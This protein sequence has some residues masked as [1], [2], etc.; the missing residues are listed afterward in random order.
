[1]LSI[2][3]NG[4]FIDRYLD[5]YQCQINSEYD[6]E[7]SFEAIDGT[8]VRTFLGTR[9]VLNV[10]FE[11]MNTQ[12]INQLF[13]AI[14]SSQD[15]T[16]T[17]IDPELGQQTRIFVCSSLPAATYFEGQ[18][19][20]GVFK[21]FWTIP[22]IIFTEKDIDNSGVVGGI[23]YDY[24]LV[25]ST[26]T[27]LANEIAKNTKISMS[28]SDE[29]F[30]VG[31][32]ASYNISGAVVLNA[33][34]TPHRNDKVMFYVR[35]KS[36]GVYTNWI[37]IHTFFLKDFSLYG[38]EKYLKF[39]AY[40]S[41]SFVD[42]DY[43]VNYTT[44][45]SGQ[46]IPQTVSQ[47]K[48][49]AEDMMNE[50]INKN[51]YN[52]IVSDI[53]FPSNCDNVRLGIN[54]STNARN[55]IQ[56]IAQSSATNYRQRLYSEEVI[57]DNFEIG[58]INSYTIYDRQ[59]TKLDVNFPG[60]FIETIILYCGATTSL[61]CKVYQDM[62]KDYDIYIVGTIPVGT[63][64]P[65]AANTLEV[66]T[67]YYGISA[68]TGGIF[69]NLLNKNF[70]A[71]FSCSKIKIDELIPIGTRIYFKDNELNDEFDNTQYFF[72][73]TSINY[74]FAKSGIYANISGSSRKAS[75]SFYLGGMQRDLEGKIKLDATYN[76]ILIDNSGVKF[77]APKAE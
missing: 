27:F 54:T 29:G 36:N 24:K 40:D 33:I 51:I 52:G 70:G 2:T 41:L 57:I 10:D 34:F 66:S 58:S 74:D 46:I 67:P 60:E 49:A 35:T 73:A 72:Y 26:Y 47:H 20:A 21:Q 28:I 42:N 5:K 38:D 62:D 32:I 7:N 11:P 18:T 37:C 1:M 13:S 76:N 22:T 45:A 55:L 9:R 43:Y 17:Y 14:R 71:Q 68:E 63:R 44:D 50:L 12:Q 75:D 23:E 8:L 39:S 77:A 19:T 56:N 48:L 4:V 3:I 6:T 59:R 69:S 65:K 16:I 25:I 30:N 31:N 15:I 64:Y 53:Q 61:P